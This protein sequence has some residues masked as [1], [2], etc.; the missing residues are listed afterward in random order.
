MLSNP[1]LIPLSGMNQEHRI[2]M[3]RCLQLAQ[4]GAGQTAPNPL[5]GAILVHEEKII[6]EGYHKIYGGPH[7]EVNC[8][9]SVSKE[10]QPKISHATLYVS[11]E[12][13]AHTGKTPPCSDLIIRE[14]IPRVV[15]GCRDPFPEVDGKG[16]EKLSSQG[17]ELLYPILE[18]ESRQVNRRFIRFHESKRPYIIL[19]WARSSDGK[20]APDSGKRLVIS[21]KF[22]NRLVHKWRSEEAGILVGSGTVVMDNPLL[23][24]RLWPGK[25]PVRILIDRKNAVPVSLSVFNPSAP[26]IIFNY[27][28]ESKI[29]NLHFKKTDPHKNILQEVMTGLYNE[30]IL[31]ILVEGGAQ[32][33]NLFIEAGLWDE[34]RVITNNQLQI[35]RGL[36]A[37]E[38]TFSRL[39]KSTNYFSDSIAYYMNEKFMI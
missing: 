35:G 18:K 4:L 31:S 9:H 28:K 15:I 34:A 32:I 1:E 22:S 10:N 33:L 3:D 13:C 38:L 39:I 21:N 24:T 17:V 16:I 20:I 7:A 29:N 5:V 8:I 11:L 36:S 37:P 23:T 2:F 12:P 30:N 26:T 19:K 25:N 27:E 14:K 6:G